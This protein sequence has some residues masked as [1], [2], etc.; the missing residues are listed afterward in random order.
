MTDEIHTTGFSRVVKYRGIPVTVIISVTK[1]M[2]FKQN[3]KYICSRNYILPVF[4]RR[5]FING[6]NRNRVK[7]VSCKSG[8]TC[9]LLAVLNEF[10]YSL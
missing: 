4:E 9:I 1:E 7:Q 10:F 8:D 5:Y 2:T 6:V 3:L